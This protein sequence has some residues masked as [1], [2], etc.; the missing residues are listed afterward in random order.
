MGLKKVD[1]SAMKGPPWDFTNC[2]AF[3]FFFAPVSLLSYTK[4]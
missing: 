3:H 2:F 1:I 4:L